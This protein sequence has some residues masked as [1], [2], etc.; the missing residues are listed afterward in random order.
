MRDAHVVVA[1]NVLHNA[2]DIGVTLGHVHRALPPGGL[3]LFTESVRDSA[4]TLT[5]MQFL[6]S[7]PAGRPRIFLDEDEWLSELDIAGFDTEPGA[8]DE[9][10]QRLFVARRR[11]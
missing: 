9:S 7:P 1:G 8:A 6:L 5:G 3:L 11:P 10:G 2:V 4:V